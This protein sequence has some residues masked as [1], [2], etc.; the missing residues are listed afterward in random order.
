MKKIKIKRDKK[1][2]LLIPSSKIHNI[3]NF[4]DD[5][6]IKGKSTFSS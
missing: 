4:L 5:S 2:S 6:I 3:F 1:F